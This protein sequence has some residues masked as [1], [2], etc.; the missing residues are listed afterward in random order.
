M[1]DVGKLTTHMKMALPIIEQVWKR[2]AGQVKLEYTA[3]A[4][5]KEFWHHS[6]WS[7]HH[8]GNAVDIRTKTLPDK[9]VGII[10]ALIGPY[11]Q[12]ALNS[13]LGK[14]K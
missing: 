6:F 12:D 4:G 10:S 11:M 14:G 3:T 9:G 5:Q 1:N 2:Y 8:S 13:R 7:W